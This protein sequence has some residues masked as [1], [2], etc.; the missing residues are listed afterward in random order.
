MN[1]QTDSTATQGAAPTVSGVL[2]SIFVPD[3]HPLLRL[4]AALDWEA[5]T[6]V[7]VRHWRQAGKNVDGGRGLP[8]V[9]QVKPVK[10]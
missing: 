4:K 7:M 9:R 6:G 1:K 8:H 2:V 5:I 10:H 3:E